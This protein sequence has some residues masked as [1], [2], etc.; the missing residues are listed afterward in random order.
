METMER[1]Q[2]FASSE[3]LPEVFF[4][5]RKLE[6]ESRQ[7]IE[8]DEELSKFDRALTER[9]AKAAQVVLARLIGEEGPDREQLYY[10]CFCLLRYMIA[11][12]QNQEPEKGAE[13]LEKVSALNLGDTSAF[14]KGMQEA[15]EEIC[16]READP[17]MDSILEYIRENFWRNDFS[18]ENVAERFHLSKTYV[19]RLFKKRLGI[20][21]IDYLSGLRMEEAR[22]KLVETDLTIQEI[23]ESVGYFDVPGFRKKFKQTYGINASQYKKNKGT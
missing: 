12:L 9:D 18:L 4:C 2:E 15:V 23:A 3:K 10:R 6:D 13:T 19:S 16:S 5:T 7:K 21:Y 8:G 11:F 20:R 1:F 17:L 14:L 22:K